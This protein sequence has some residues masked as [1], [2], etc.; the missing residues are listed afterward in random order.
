M[1][2]N[3]FINNSVLF[4]S[5][6]CYQSN[7]EIH[8]YTS[9]DINNIYYKSHDRELSRDDTERSVIKMKPCPTEREIKREKL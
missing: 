7:R 3:F 1:G 4:F 8:I 5:L 9:L 2:M 6:R